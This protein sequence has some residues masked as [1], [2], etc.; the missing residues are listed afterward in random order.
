MAAKNQILLLTTPLPANYKIK[1]ILGVVTGSTAR[2]RG[3]GGKFIAS[4]ESVF[5]G[6]VTAFTQEME[7]ARFEAIERM[8]EK[9]AALGANVV[10]GIDIETTE[11]FQGTVLVSATGTALIS[12]SSK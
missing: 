12:S 5:G 2:T 3:V 6:E 9:A 4:I 8:R 7:K 11:V 10:C 1:E